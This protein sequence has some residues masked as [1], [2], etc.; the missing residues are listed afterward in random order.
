MDGKLQSNNLF[1]NYYEFPQAA[2]A[3]S[4]SSN[5][6]GA[7]SAYAR[8]G[9]NSVKIS[10]GPYVVETARLLPIVTD[11]FYNYPSG[12]F[13]MTAHSGNPK[14]QWGVPYAR[15]AGQNAFWDDGHVEWQTWTGGTIAGTLASKHLLENLRLNKLTE[16]F[17]TIYADYY[18]AW[19]K[20]GGP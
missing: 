5:I 1:Y 12:P 2:M 20:P 15:P 14:P 9:T 16:G 4:Y 6:G 17:V 7:N 10:Y 19:A 13:N 11:K 3:L 8:V 18:V